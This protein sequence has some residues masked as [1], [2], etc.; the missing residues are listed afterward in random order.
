MLLAAC[1]RRRK[2]TAPFVA[3]R[4]LE[5]KG[6]DAQDLLDTTGPE[7]LNPKPWQEVWDHKVEVGG[8]ED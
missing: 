2:V 5:K 7:P 3:E 6:I 1:L 8:F 4:P